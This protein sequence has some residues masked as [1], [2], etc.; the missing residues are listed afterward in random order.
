MRLICP[1]CRA[2]YEV[3]DNAI[4][5]NGREV[6][7]GSCT[8]TWFQEPDPSVLARSLAERGEVAPP[9]VFKH[10]G[11]ARSPASEDIPAPQPMP[12]ESSADR[13]KLLREIRAEA[14]QD[15][16]V[17]AS[18]RIEREPLPREEAVDEDTS[19][20]FEQPPQKSSEPVATPRQ[21]ET[22]LDTSDVHSYTPPTDIPAPDP[23]GED[24]FMQNIRSQIEAQKDLP[25]ETYEGRSSS[26]IK[27]AENAGIAIDTVKPA[28][29]PPSEAERTQSMQQSI[30]ELS[31][32]AEAPKRRRS[33]SVGVY[34]AAIL[35][36]LALA[37]YLLRDQISAYYPPAASWLQAY[38]SLIDDARLFVQDLYA[39]AR[40][41]VM[42]F[43][44]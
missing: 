15:L 5:V 36:L 2:Q 31:E 39:M 43:F 12:D 30:R 7:C 21:A 9:P 38:A 24:A 3:D 33:Y 18:S 40:N 4:P 27:A 41:F 32:P 29:L 37:T 23:A 26:V 17:R 6:Q 1:S 42:G 35:F 10:Q 34:T 22:D 25:P 11:L 28:P 14:E 13:E 20:S 19:F 8:T 16:S 44:A